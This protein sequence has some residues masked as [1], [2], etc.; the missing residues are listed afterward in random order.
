MTAIQIVS[1]LLRMVGKIN[2]GFFL[3][4]YTMRMNIVENVVC[5]KPIVPY[6]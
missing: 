1:D 3:Y 4:T 2:W 5:K 6:H